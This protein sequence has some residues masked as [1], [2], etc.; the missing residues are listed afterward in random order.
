[1]EVYYHFLQVLLD[2][3][4]RH[5]IPRLIPL[6]YQVVVYFDPHHRH[7]R[8]MLLLKKLKD[9]HLVLVPVDLALRLLHQLLQLL[10]KLKHKL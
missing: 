8:L 7:Q 3:L 2:L 1:M 6:D 4:H 10:D 5:Q 9:Y